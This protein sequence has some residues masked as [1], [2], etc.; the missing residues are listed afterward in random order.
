MRPARDRAPEAPTVRIEGMALFG[1]WGISSQA[2]D[3]PA[4]DVL[5]PV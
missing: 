5:A 1:G 3:E 2:G 4:E